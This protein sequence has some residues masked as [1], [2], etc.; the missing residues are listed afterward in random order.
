MTWFCIPI[1]AIAAIVAHYIL[2]NIRAENM[3]RQILI[4]K[5]LELLKLDMENIGISETEILQDIEQQ[6]IETLKDFIN[7]WGK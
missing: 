1:T 4:N 5:C 3:E 6:D 7:M 2:N